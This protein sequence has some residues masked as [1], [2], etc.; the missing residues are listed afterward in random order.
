MP[1][2]LSVCCV[3]RDPGARV[4]AALLPLRK[5]ADEIVV[6]VDAT[7]DPE[8]LGAYESV[9]DVLVRFEFGPPIESSFEWLKNLCSGEWVFRLDGDE[10]VSP[11]LIDALPRLVQAGD[12]IQYW[13]PCR[14]VHPD[15]RRWFDEW[16]W[17]P[18]FLNR[19]VRNDAG[20][21]F[22]GLSHSNAAP[23]LPAR[24]VEH[25][26]YHLVCALTPKSVRERKVQSYLDIEAAHKAAGS[27]RFLRQFYLPED[28]A[29]LEPVPIPD[30][31]LV[32]VE[33]ALSVGD[34]NAPTK[35]ES[36]RLYTRAEIE[37]VWPHRPLRQS[38]YR[39]SIEPLSSYRRMQ[40]GLHN[41]FRVSVRNEGDTHWPGGHSRSP[42]IRLSY[43]WRAKDGGVIAEGVRSPL[44]GP[45]APGEACVAPVIVAAPE[46][47]GQYTLQFDLVHENVRWF[48]CPL[49]I[50]MRIEPNTPSPP[51][52]LES[53][54]GLATIRVL[55]RY[56]WLIA[57]WRAPF[58]VVARNDQGADWPGADPERPIRL[59]Y[60]WFRPGEAEPVADGFRT[61]FPVAVRPGEEVIVPMV[62]EG[63]AVPG[64]Y[65]LEIDVV[66]E[67]VRWFG[68]SERVEVDVRETDRAP[69]LE[70][71]K[72][73]PEW[74]ATADPQLF[75]RVARLCGLEHEEALTL[76]FE[77]GPPVAIA[78]PALA[79]LPIRLRP[80]TSD[81]RVFDDTFWGRFHLPPPELHAPELIVDLGSNIGLTMVDFC[82]LFPQARVIGVELDQDSAA[83]ARQNV[84]PWSDRITIVEAAI[85]S[86]DGTVSYGRRPDDAWAHR[87]GSAA[88]GQEASVRAMKLDALLDSLAPDQ[89]IDYLKVDIEGGERELFRAGG[90]WSERVR[91]L[92]VEVHEPYTVTECIADLSRLGLS[93]SPEEG[94]WATVV[95]RGTRAAGED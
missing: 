7:L 21:Q 38:A 56:R 87:V 23:E 43:H 27:D 63:P 9:A 26:L 44:P 94:H 37:S 62:V 82:F 55:D 47:P 88:R 30:Q 76:L 31:D 13:F 79:G 78:I 77:A 6:A 72:E 36:V 60:R 64:R 83:L 25:P 19:L 4:A 3:T 54:D 71:P 92:K 5:I 53:A 86:E 52:P 11:T 95:A 75:D 2:R 91:V 85:W 17:S 41:P 35:A 50:G 33:R 67:F 90:R 42:V 15:G 58:C 93:A 61:A 68:Q 45:L 14:W 22:E 80:W 10:V 8:H 81:L 40:P 89:T 66:R 69:L 84:E 48:D 16:P 1:L 20:L 73:A 46:E 34:S 28:S 65:M 59:G 18:C 12:V 57:G 74:L 39:A 70:V 24:F 49:A 51:R 29:T 32:L